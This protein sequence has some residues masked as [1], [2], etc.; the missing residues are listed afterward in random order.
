MKLSFDVIGKSLKRAVDPKAANDL[1]AFLEQLPQH[2][3]KTML[4]IVALIWASAATLGLFTA[5][6]MQELSEL[7]NELADAEALLP[8][9]P[10]VRNKPISSQELSRF[11]DH[12]SEI[13]KGLEIKSVSSNI[14][15]RANSTSYFGQFREAVGH[16]QNGG[17]G[18]RVS[19]EKMCMGQECKQHP[20]SA[21]LSINTVSVEN[22]SR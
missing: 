22:V 21:T 1:N 17:L 20:L 3:G 7:S 4:V 9:V 16:I 13:Y 19:V 6:K 8:S 5:V 10:A 18:W 2:T 14:V 11:V 15:I 12:L